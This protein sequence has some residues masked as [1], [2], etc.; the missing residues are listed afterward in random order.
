VFRISVKDYPEFDQSNVIVP[1][2]GTVSLP[3]YGTLRVGGQ[4]VAQVQA[5][6][7]SR[8][9]REL[10]NPGVAVSITQFRPAAPLVIGRVYL[11]GAGAA[12]GT[13]EIRKGF[14]LTEVL[15]AAGGLSGRMEEMRATLTR[16]GSAPINL[17]LQNAI[18]RPGSAANIL[19]R[20]ND[21]LTISKV[22]PGRIVVSGDVLR[23]DT[24]EMHQNPLPQNREVSLAPRLS[25]VIL[26]AGGLVRPAGASSAS[27]GSGAGSIQP[28]VIAGGVRDEDVR[29]EGT[30]QRGGVRIPLDIAAALEDVSGPDNFALK[31]G[32]FVTIKA[33]L[34]PPPPAPI[35]VF[36]DGFVARSGSFDVAP[37]AR[38]LQ[39]L[40]EAGGVSQPLEKVV[41]SV[42]RGNEIL[43][44]D[45]KSVLLSADSA[46]NFELLAGDV[47][48]V[49]EPDVIRVQAAGSVARAGVLRLRPGS[50]LLE[51]LLE[52]G[53][54]SIKA[55][56]ARL[57]VLRKEEDGSQKVLAADA[58]ALLELRSTEGNVVL[59]DGDLINVSPRK[60]QTIF[61]SGEVNSP[62]PFEVREGEGLAQLIIRAG[63]AKDT[64]AL[65]RVVVQRG[66]Q[67]MV[68]DVREALKEGKPLA[69][70]LQNNDFVVVPA[71]TEQVLVMEAVAKPGY[72]PIPEKGVLTLLDALGQAGGPSARTKEVVLVR[73]DPNGT[74]REFRIPMTRVR[75]GAEGRQ[76][77]RN[78][79]IVFVPTTVA[80]PN[81]L[82][83]LGSTLGLFRIF[84]P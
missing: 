13:V 52:A 45:L 56:D 29:Y 62:G 9:R 24:F 47:L 73:R 69:F 3:F 2:D 61:I 66:G 17:N 64:A 12:Q 70:D 74:A 58:A 25:D 5:V 27:S 63:G 40:T 28:G 19:V 8:L 6:V 14:R 72:Y 81:L 10:R 41:A 35:K 60:N 65:T 16:A 1:P 67:N 68:Q 71:N 78:G 42:R 37:G 21:V 7:R 79:D 54:L 43:P 39:V 23:P 15:S 33:V 84:M 26:A 11:V 38:V 48:Q 31:A 49:R 46:S 83:Q 76:A 18:A 4:T 22:A 30:L 44:I 59:R 57:S 75:S 53:G 80:K 55:E 50:T 51:G 77:L 32:D 82:Q 34:P 20:P 36:V